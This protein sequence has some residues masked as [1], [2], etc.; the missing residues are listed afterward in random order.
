MSSPEV[1]H[2]L[3]ALGFTYTRL[4]EALGISQ[5]M[6]SLWLN[7]KRPVPAYH[8]HD[9]IR[10]YLKAT[11]LADAGNDPQEAF[12]T[13]QPLTLVTENT[14]GEVAAVSHTGRIALPPEIA[15]LLVQLAVRRQ[16]GEI[17]TETQIMLQDQLALVAG[18]RTLQKMT[19][20]DP[21]QMPLD[22]DAIDVLLATLAGLTLTVERLAVD[23]AQARA[24][25]QTPTPKETPHAN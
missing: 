24:Q 16:R 14:A 4:A 6:L 17:T 9:L 8:Y 22:A 5:P 25:A 12:T 11:E 1:L 3:K 21:W 23:L 7:G 13:W 2:W 18:L 15:T 10:L 19:P 20:T